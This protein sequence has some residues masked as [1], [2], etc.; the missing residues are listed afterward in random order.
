M[1][2]L[3]RKMLLLPSRP[4]VVL[5]QQLL[6]PH[7][8]TFWSNTFSG[9]SDA[10]MADLASYYSLPLLSMRDALWLLQRAR[11]SSQLCIQF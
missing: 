7:P 11:V 5:L 3:I 8:R 10:G 1:E 9:T 4:V 6:P 2:L